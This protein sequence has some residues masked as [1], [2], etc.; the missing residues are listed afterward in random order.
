M[1]FSPFQNAELRMDNFD[2]TSIGSLF[3]LS[4]FHPGNSDDYFDED[5][6]E[7]RSGLVVHVRDLVPN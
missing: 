5:S 3:Y 1:H 4:F 6:L 2:I 7:S